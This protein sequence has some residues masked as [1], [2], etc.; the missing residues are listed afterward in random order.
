MTEQAQEPLSVEE[1]KEPEKPAIDVDGLMSEL[2]KAGITNAG[3]L[4]GKLRASQ[5]SGRLAQL[6]GDERKRTAEYE[7]KLREYTTTPPPAP[8]QDFMDYGEGQSIDIE[9]A[10]ERSVSKVIN[11][12][13]E[14][15]RIAQEQNLQKW[16]HIRS[17]EDYEVVKEIWENKLKDPNFVYQIQAGVIDPV[18]DF[19]NTKTNYYK[20]L[21]RRSHET[22]TTMRG[23]DKVN[24]PHIESGS[25]TSANMV[26]ETPSGTDAD[27]KLAE[28]KAKTDKGYMMTGEEELDL[29]DTI[30]GNTTPL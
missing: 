24:P 22:I 17:D 6:L 15:Q 14:A 18:Q 1:P 20:T 16:N 5:E 4:T 29:I 25:R 2:E 30:F 27:R 7:A 28:M 10:I 21:L 9:A 3:E 19:N 11:K 23:G 8:K 12:E 26:S 13:K